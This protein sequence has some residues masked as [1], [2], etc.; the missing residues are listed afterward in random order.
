MAEH[1]TATK[2]RPTRG[3][4]VVLALSVAFFIASRT[5]GSGW[6]TTLIA[7]GFGLVAAG[8]IGPWWAI[9]SVSV[10]ATAPLDAVAGRPFDITIT[11][12]GR[13]QYLQVRSVTPEGDWFGTIANNAE[14]VRV[15]AKRRG[16]IARA[17][18][19][20]STGTPVGLAWATRIFHVDLPMPIAVAPRV[21]PVAFSATTASPADGDEAEGSRT[22]QGESVRS[23]R[24]YQPGDP[25]RMIHWAATAKTGS[26]VVKE[27]ES[28][29][30]PLL[31]VRLDLN[32]TDFEGDERSEIAYGHVQ[33][34]LAAGVPVRLL[35]CEW[36]GPHHGRVGSMLEAGRR[37]AHATPGRPADPLVNEQPVTVVTI[38]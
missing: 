2:L 23:V 24:D 31:V 25:L 18:I 9:R 16:V 1:I 20:V 28:P 29:D 37:L 5:T 35:T 17:T 7:V 4:G 14:T 30:A 12:T 32:C 3:V 13:S 6:L 21:R 19:E 15:V 34:G 22:G 33:R 10:A 11:P 38:P 36:S 26:P 27:L 8:V